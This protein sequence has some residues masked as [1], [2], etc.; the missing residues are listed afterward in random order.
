MDSGLKL[1]KKQFSDDNSN[2]YMIVLTDGL[3]NLA[4]GHND[5]VSYEGE[6]A[7]IT[8]TK[9]TLKSFENTNVITMLTGITD[10]EATFRTDGTNTYTYGQIIEEVF[11]T[12]ENPTIGKFYKINDNE[13]EK[14]ITS[15]I[16]NDLLPVSKELKDITVV[17][18]FPQY[19][20]DNFEMTYVEG[21]DTKNVS[22]AIDTETNSITWKLSKV[23]PGEEV[24]IQYVLKT[25]DEID[26]KILDQVLDTNQKIEINY[27]DFDEKTQTKSSEVTPKIKLTKIPEKPVTPEEPKD[28]TIAPEPI[29][30]AGTPFI[31][32]GMI[33][34]LLVTIFFGIKSRKIR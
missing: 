16:H 17:D 5:L 19:I 34:M 23:A 21:T 6:K 33:A 1:A 31:M 7:V 4:V 28:P 11:G 18:Y 9:K 13:I 20:V 32:I 14:T 15:E 3:P 10:E 24:K 27:K 26:E 29:P 12:E 22:S 25:K 30:N 2:K 8:E